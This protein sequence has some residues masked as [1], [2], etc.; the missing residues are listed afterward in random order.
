MAGEGFP[1]G[2]PLGHDL[3]V[4]PLDRDSARREYAAQFRAGEVLEDH[5][6]LLYVN[7]HVGRGED[8]L[9]AAEGPQ[10][11]AHGP[12]GVDGS[13]LLPPPEAAMGLKNQVQQIRHG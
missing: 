7:G 13:C 5:A 3:A 10:E 12:L 2:G 6:L 11:P 9:L 1:W 8:S 4:P